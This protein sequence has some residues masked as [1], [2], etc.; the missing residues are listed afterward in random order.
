MNLLGK[1]V[2]LSLCG[3]NVAHA[4]SPVIQPIQIGSETIRF[5]QGVPTLDLQGVKGAVQVTPLALD[6]GGVSFG[7]AVLNDSGQ[8]VN[9]DISNFS[10]SAN[11]LPLKVYSK[12]EL[13]KKAQKRAMWTQIALATLGGLSAAA[14]ASQTNT[15]T[16]T[17]YTPRGTYHSIYTAP[18]VAGQ[19]QAGVIAAGTGVS[20]AAVQNH[21]DA[22][23]EALGNN[24]VQITTL[25]S[26]ES[27][28]GQIIAEKVKAPKLPQRVDLSVSWN[29]ETYPFAFQVAKSGTA[30]PAFTAL[31]GMTRSREASRETDVENKQIVPPSVALP[32]SVMP[33]PSVVASSPGK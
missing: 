22:T 25:D 10:L 30:Q 14:A 4:A 9:V 21:L 26:G 7:V 15:Y 16:G 27:Y 17:L 12:D 5:K 33:T 19:I 20:I 2:A 1:V 11:G 13:V 8:P 31:T 28:S 24:I 6:H 3:V 23:R 29:G 18:S 32:T